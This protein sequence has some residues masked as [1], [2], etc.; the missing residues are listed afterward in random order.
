MFRKE[1]I[2][3]FRWRLLLT[4]GAVFV[5]V[6]GGLRWIPA[7]SAQATAIPRIFNYQA[8]I[9]NNLGVT[10]ANGALNMGFVIYDASTGGNCLWSAANTDSNTATVDCAVPNQISITATDG[11]VSVLLGDTTGST[12]NAIPAFADSVTTLYLGIRV[13]TDSEMTPRKRIVS[14]LLAEEAADAE[15]LD[16]FN[17]S[18]TGGTSAF[19]PV[20]ASTGNLALTGDPQGSGVTQ[21]ALAINPATA[22]VAA[23]DTLFGIALDGVSLF[24]VDGE[25]DTSV[26]GGLALSSDVD[27]TLAGSENIT[28]SNTTASADLF[29][30]SAT[31]STSN[32][33][34]FQI[35]FTASNTSQIFNIT[36]TFSTTTTS[37]H[38]VLNVNDFTTTADGAGAV[39][40]L[41]AF[42]VGVLTQSELNGG[43]VTA[44]TFE[45]SPGWD[46]ILTGSTASG[47][48]ISFTNFTVTSAGDMTIAGGDL[49]GA[50]SE[51]IDLGEA[52]NNEIQ[53]T[54]GGN[55][56]YQ[57][58]LDGANPSIQ[59]TDGDSLIIEDANG[60]DIFSLADV[61]SA[62]N[63]TLT[64][65][66]NTGLVLS[67]MTTDLTTETN[68]NLT[69]TAA[70]TGDV[71]LTLDAD[72][73]ALYGFS[74]TATATFISGSYGATTTLASGATVVGA[75]IDV[76]TNL[77][78]D[79]AGNNLTGLLLT[80]DSGGAGLTYGLDIAG[81]AD[82]GI[83]I[84]GATTDI[85]TPD[86]EDL[87]IT[88]GL[89]GQINIATEA[90]AHTINIGTGAGVV[91]TLNLGTGTG[92]N[93]IRIGT[94]N[95][96]ADTI[97]IGSALDT[98]TLRGSTITIGNEADASVSIADAF[99]SID[100]TG[101][102]NFGTSTVTAGTFTS[103]SG[104]FNSNF[105]AADS[106]DIVITG[107]A[108]TDIIFNDAGGNVFL[109]VTDQGTHGSYTLNGMLCIRNLGT[110]PSYAAGRLYV[111][112]VGTSS[113]DIGDTFD[114]AEFYPASEP[115]EAGDLLVV[116]SSLDLRVKKAP[117]GQ[118]DMLLGIAS[119]TP[120]IAIEEGWFG[121][122]GVRQRDPLKPLVALVGRVPIKVTN[123]NGSIEP[124]DPLTA[125]RTLAGYAMKATE[126]SYVVGIALEH[127][128]DSQGKVRAFVNPGWWNGTQ[129]A[130]AENT[131]SRLETGQLSVLD[132]SGGN[133][134][135]SST[136]LRVA[137]LFSLGGNWSLNEEGWLS[138]KEVQTETLTTEA[139]TLRLSDRRQMA[140]NGTIPQGGQIFRVNNDAARPS[141][142]IFVTFR[143]RPPGAWWISEAGNGWFEISLENPLSEGEAS[144]DYWILQIDDVRSPTPFVAPPL[145]DP[146]SPSPVEEVL[147][148]SEDLGNTSSEPA[149]T[150]EPLPEEEVLPTPS[151]APVVE[152]SIIEES[153]IVA[154]ETE[155]AP[156]IEETPVP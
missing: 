5:L 46:N 86:L 144:F 54:I 63:H 118:A 11:V 44:N 145:P 121:A 24:R 64:G 82:T 74:G 90:A 77:T 69:L 14:A 138:V 123:E 129:I 93:T 72:T 8:K 73:Q 109:R 20:T 119:R 113:D 155:A 76:D 60:T 22:Q 40:T 1:T 50:N 122:G 142:K 28:V 143:S 89:A 146:V 2:W 9:T 57:F 4:V 96:A 114:L 133:S 139:V 65:D 130:R 39:S 125:S 117:A 103:F 95:T 15:L 58:A 128:M 115:V 147:S 37:T 106:G 140:G 87:N 91:E 10:V 13:G 127:F 16:G 53:F 104:G 107:D 25:G 88:A 94:N 61:S 120:A 149:P 59:I 19:V 136:S 80:V 49:T 154:S 43:V 75:S 48:L 92:G 126:P 33:D 124:G 153:Q 68:G 152:S 99:W 156:V 34:A 83:R 98:M 41:N 110:C 132:F 30:I 7:P 62:N 45:I 21:G 105:T 135:S 71:S 78:M 134:F 85:T 100:A 84:G 116:D 35:N 51:A 137:S 101:N 56:E 112:T 3:L 12:Q 70:G 81:S 42:R 29:S 26:T 108:D 148:P 97:S 141:S 150:E 52:T 47:N 27:A 111:D 32:A 151:E 18:Q 6:F 23:N 17:T 131:A 67:G 31:T 36:P 38:R 66:A 79:A 55:V 102:A